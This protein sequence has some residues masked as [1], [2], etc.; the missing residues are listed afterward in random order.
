MQYCIISN[1]VGDLLQA[2]ANGDANI[3]CDEIGVSGNSG[4]GDAAW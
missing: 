2:I 4:V 1:A 3:A